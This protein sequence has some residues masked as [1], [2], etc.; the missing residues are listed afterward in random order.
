MTKQEFLQGVRFYIPGGGQE[1]GADFNYTDRNS[2][3]AIEKNYTS[4]S[5]GKLIIVDSEV[6]VSKITN[7]GFRGYTF[8]MGKRVKVFHKFE[9][10]LV[11]ENPSI[12]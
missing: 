4:S 8:V 1:W 11:V 3:S 12:R 2:L 5:T 7:L 9:D 6:N 10:L